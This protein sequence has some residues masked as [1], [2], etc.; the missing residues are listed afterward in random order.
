MLTRIQEGDPIR[1]DWC[2]DKHEFTIE[3]D[4]SSLATWV[5]L[6]ANESVVKDVNWLYPANNV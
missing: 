1:G 2:V 5:V 6:E 3:V 4:T